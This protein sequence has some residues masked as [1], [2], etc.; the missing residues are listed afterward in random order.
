MMNRGHFDVKPETI[1]VLSNGVDS[2]DSEFKF[3]DIGLSSRGSRDSES[4]SNE[5]QAAPTYGKSTLEAG[6]L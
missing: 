2:S 1:S 3:A 4:T 5:M 6:Y